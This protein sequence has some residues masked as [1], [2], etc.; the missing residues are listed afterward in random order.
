M[1]LAELIDRLLRAIRT[2]IIVRIWCRG[3]D[4]SMH[5]DV[6]TAQ[7]TYPY[8]HG[9]IHHSIHRRRFSP[10]AWHRAMK[11]RLDLFAIKDGMTNTRGCLR[12]SSYKIN[13]AAS[14]KHL[15]S[16]RTYLNW[17]PGGLPGRVGI[18]GTRLDVCWAWPSV[19]IRL[20]DVDGFT[21]KLLCRTMIMRGDDEESTRCKYA[22]VVVV[23]IALMFL[24]FLLT[25]CSSVSVLKS[26]I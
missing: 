18:A 19:G 21:L 22:V 2:E 20:S 11:P 17:A 14:G 8:H 10:L 24:C 1:L 25:N 6:Q 26:D 3:G 4:W 15:S 12:R 5:V 16:S 9:P 23:S 7:A 13:T